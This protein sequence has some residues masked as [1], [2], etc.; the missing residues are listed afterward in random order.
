[1]LYNTCSPKSYQKEKQLAFCV[2]PYWQ[3]IV[4]HNKKLTSGHQNPNIWHVEHNK[5]QTV[6]W[7]SNLQLEK[8]TRLKLAIE[9]I[10]AD[11]CLF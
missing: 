9:L 2:W 1:M 5:R 7:C 8:R 11:G 4:P 6:Y 3:Q 10:N